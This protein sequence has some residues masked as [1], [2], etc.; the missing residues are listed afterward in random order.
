M[1]TKPPSCGPFLL[2][3]ELGISL[4]RC[5]IHMKCQALFSWNIEKKNFNCCLLHFYWDLNL[6]DAFIYL[7]FFNLKTDYQIQ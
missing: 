1:L 2:V 5:T 4:V 7:F 3:L 6:N